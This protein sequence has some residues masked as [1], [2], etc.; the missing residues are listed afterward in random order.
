MDRQLTEI[1]NRYSKKE[2]I[3]L[4]NSGIY[5][6]EEQIFLVDETITDLEILNTFEGDIV[7]ISNVQFL[8]SLSNYVRPTWVNRYKLVANHPYNDKILFIFYAKS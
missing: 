1:V 7:Y 4:K 3:E 6:I 8:Y 2:L 5:N